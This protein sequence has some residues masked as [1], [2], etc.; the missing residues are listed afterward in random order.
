MP[1]D[2]RAAMKKLDP[3][4]FAEIP[5]KFVG[6]VR[7]LGPEMEGEVRV[8]LA[9]FETPLWPSV[10]RGARVTYAEVYRR[11]KPRV[12]AGD[13]LER[14]RAGGIDAVVVTSV[15]GLENLFEMLADGD[16]GWLLRAGCL[17][18]PVSRLFSI[19]VRVCRCLVAMI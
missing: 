16:A 9:T 4:A 7:I 14:G 3:D 13:V 11:A 10:A 6:P 18:R 15:Q 5:M 8:P 12:D 2:G 1:E 17:P 19:R